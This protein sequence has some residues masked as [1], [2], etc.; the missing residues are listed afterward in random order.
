MPDKTP[1]E[2]N[3]LPQPTAAVSSDTP[4]AA[5]PETKEVNVVPFREKVLVGMGGMTMFHGNTTVKAT[6]MPFFNMILGVNPA[7]LGLAL[8]IPRIWDAFTD[9]IMGRISDRFHSRWG[10][11]RPFIVLGAILMSLSFG[12]IWMVPTTWSE[13]GIMAW[14]LIASLI[15]YTCFT[16]F[17]V[18]FTS[19]T[20]EL[21]PN[22]NERTTVMGYV[23]LWTKVSEF[24]YQGLIPVAGMLV[25]WGLFGTQVNSIRAV[26]WGVAILMILV[27]GMMPGIFGRE[28][29]Y[30]VK[31]KEEA[32]L[33]K[34]IGFWKTVGQTFSNRAFAVLI[35]LTLLQIIA[36]FFGSTLDYYLLVYYMFDGDIVTGS[37]WKWYLSMAY[38]VCGFGGI[39]V[40]L[41]LSKRTSKLITL[42]IV[43]CLVIFNG[44]VRWFVYNPGNHHFIFV[45]AI[46]GSLYWIA[47]GT[48]MQSMMA[49]ICDD[50]EF[51]HN[52]RREGMFAAVFGWVTK[53]AVSAAMLIGGVSLVMVGF[54]SELGGNQTASTFLG[55]RL[56]MVLGGM[57][58]NATALA[59]LTLYPITKAK[60]EETRRQLEERRGKV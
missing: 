8:A 42:R 17:A 31:V 60:A 5:S 37:L 3:P 2:N 14:F 41:W 45:D 18:P 7:L 1:S 59:L 29:Y 36:G 24:T 33:V 10:R 40:I 12:M 39:P 49:D 4:G 46:F 53:A 15:F 58:P 21:T 23:T 57:I 25:A 6:A 27:F 32:H 34:R 54:D 9:P 13:G 52:E 19:M 35:S 47:V 48:V 51:K 30:K 20:Y 16:I 22:Y 50:D 56:V 11:R 44:I 38:A 26:M 55:M 28:R 43:Y